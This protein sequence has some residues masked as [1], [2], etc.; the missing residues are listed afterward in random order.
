MQKNSFLAYF[1]IK[2]NLLHYTF[3]LHM[4]SFLGDSNGSSFDYTL[5][6]WL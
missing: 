1:L 5:T 6:A 2:N 3:V 4:H